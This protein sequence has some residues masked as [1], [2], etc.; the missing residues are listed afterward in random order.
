MRHRGIV[1]GGTHSGC[2]KTTITMGIIR[3][4][5]NRGLNVQPW[6]AGPDYI[7]PGFHSKAAE[8]VCRNLDTMILSDSVVKE[9]YG[10]Q[11]CDISLIEGVMGLFDGV[12]GLDERGSA[13]HLSKL[14]K[15]PVVVVIDARAMARSGG[16]VALGFVEFDKDVNVA[17]FILNRVGSDRHYR[18][19]KESIE[20]RTGLPVLG[21]LPRDER[22]ALPERHLGLVPAWEKEDFEATLETLA[23]LVEEMIDIDS[24]M[25]IAGET[26]ELTIENPSVFSDSSRRENRIRIAVARDASF[27]FYYE[28]NLDLLRHFGAEIIHF[29]PLH[30]SNLPD[31]VSAIYIGGGYP[32]LHGEELSDNVSLIS[33]I[34]N[35]CEGGMPLYGECGGFMYLTEGIVN[36]EGTLFRMLSLLPG[37]TSM[38]KKMRA[39]GYCESVFNSDNILGN[40]GCHAKGHVFHWAGLEGVSEER[41][42]ILTV[43][44]GDEILEEGFINKNVMGSWV[45]LHFAS[46]PMLA[47]SFVDMAEKYRRTL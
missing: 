37:R 12:G 17:G 40:R 18:M 45:H 36:D 47:A 1:I 8:R 30:D 20:E 13:A 39:L 9:I 26:E 35:R 16:A 38:G 6:K 27:H 43:T 32:E 11:H 46:N 34:R 4:L 21:R 7:D 42:K 22:L 41:E 3:A 31:D 28:E 15:M 10:R 29:S 19:L 24:I 2:G 44:K 25:A 5:K 23:D 33:E 14:L